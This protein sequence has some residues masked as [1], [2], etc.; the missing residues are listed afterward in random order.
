MTGP[1]WA[2]PTFFNVPAG[3]MTPADSAQLTFPSLA[4]DDPRWN[5]FVPTT[6]DALTAPVR[7]REYSCSIGE[8][9]GPVKVTVDTSVDI[10]AC[11]NVDV[12][13]LDLELQADLV[14]F[15][16]SFS[17]T[18]SIKIRTGN[19]PGDERRRSLYIVVI[20]EGSAGVCDSR[21][22]GITVTN[23]MWDQRDSDGNIRTKVLLFT[24][25]TVYFTDRTNYP[26]NGQIYG[27]KVQSD[28]GITMQF[29]QVGKDATNTLWD[30]ELA[31][32]RDITAG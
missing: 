28:S 3:S 22:G 17:K 19:K 15:V 27:C 30:L 18:D 20:P 10:T 24:P 12:R 32:V 8:W 26:F 14:L 21:A 2:L 11:P 5:S 9:T 16:R 29:A 7:K 31:S 23:P 6:W 4:M 25:G 1:A 13:N